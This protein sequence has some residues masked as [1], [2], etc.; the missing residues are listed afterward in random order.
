MDQDLAEV[1]FVGLDVGGVWLAVGMSISSLERHTTPGSPG[2]VLACAREARAAELAAG[3]NLLVA[4]VEWAAA[5]S[6]AMPS[7]EPW[8]RSAACITSQRGQPRR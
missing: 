8:V 2:D 6:S 1:P 5:E 4:A 3:V 7:T